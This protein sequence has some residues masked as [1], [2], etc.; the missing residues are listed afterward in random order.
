MLKYTATPADSV[1]A[2]APASPTAHRMS[3]FSQ[4][5]SVASTKSAQSSIIPRIVVLR[6]RKTAGSHGTWTSGLPQRG[7]SMNCFLGIGCMREVADYESEAATGLAGG[8][9]SRINTMDSIAMTLNT[10]NGTS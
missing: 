2:T 10:I 1:A 5:A 6:R 4:P 8:L 3:L 9:A 7:H